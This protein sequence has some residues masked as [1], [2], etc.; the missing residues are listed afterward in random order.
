MLGTTSPDN[1]E[2][3]TNAAI[4]ALRSLANQYS[5]SAD[6]AAGST[7]I[8]YSQIAKAYTTQANALA[9]NGNGSFRAPPYAGGIS[10]TDKA[11][12][13]LN[14]DRVKPQY[15]LDMDDNCLPVGQ[16]D[17]QSEVPR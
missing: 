17:N 4:Q 6:R 3:V 14:Q 8:K 11:T 5:R 13:R 2:A 12:Q 9:R 1:P 15:A 7:S 16:G 10:R